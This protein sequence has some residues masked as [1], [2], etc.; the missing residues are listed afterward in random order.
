MGAAFDALAQIGTINTDLARRMK[1]AVGFRNLAVRQYEA[2]G[3]RIVHALCTKHLDDYRTFA[4]VILTWR[5][6]GQ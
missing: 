2:M 3:W 1:S 5:L 6:A 4:R